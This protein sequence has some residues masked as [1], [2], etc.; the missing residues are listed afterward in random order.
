VHYYIIASIYIW[1]TNCETIRAVKYT[2]TYTHTH[3]RARARAWNHNFN[4]KNL[5]KIL[6]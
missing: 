2:H 5:K 3:T 6:I 4:T 1:I